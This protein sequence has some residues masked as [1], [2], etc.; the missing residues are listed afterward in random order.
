MSLTRRGRVAVAVGALVLGLGVGA[1]LGCSRWTD[2]Q[3]EQSR[4][5]PVQTTEPGVDERYCSAYAAFQAAVG[6]LGAAAGTEA[7]P[8][9]LAVV[10]HALVEWEESAPAELGE[11]TSLMASSIRAGRQVST[12]E[13]VQAAALVHGYLAGAC[14]EVLVVE[15]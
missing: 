5:Q 9:A 7:E 3:R 6:L 8:T 14:P 12:V 4:P 1:G 13:D 2:D 10:D 15:A 11:A